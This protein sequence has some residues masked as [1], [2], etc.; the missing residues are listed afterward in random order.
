MSYTNLTDYKIIY[1]T[2]YTVQRK[3][4]WY[5]LED[6]PMD[7]RENLQLVNQLKEL[8]LHYMS[9]KLYI[10]QLE[11]NLFGNVGL[12]NFKSDLW[13]ISKKI[14]IDDIIMY[15]KTPNIMW[16]INKNRLFLIDFDSG[17]YNEDT[18]K[19]FQHLLEKDK[20]KILSEGKKLFEEFKKYHSSLSKTNL[21]KFFSKKQK[22][23]YKFT[24]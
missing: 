15:V 11:W 2:V 6:L 3:I 16:D 8:H 5:T 23:N 24:Q 22:A 7:I 20:D 18:E 4:C 1:P 17:S 19:V 14:N 21:K 10:Y 12:V 13:K 9:L